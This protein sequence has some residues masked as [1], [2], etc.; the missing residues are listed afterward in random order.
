MATIDLTLESFQVP[1]LAEYTPPVGTKKS[2]GGLS[3][4]EVND[5][6]MMP[7]LKQRPVEIT[8][9]STT[10]ASGVQSV[11]P[12]QF[13]GMFVFTAS[14]RVQFTLDGA[15]FV[16]C[17]A[18]FLNTSA[19]IQDVSGINLTVPATPTYDA[20]TVHPNGRIT[21]VW[22]GTE[23]LREEKLGVG[24]QIG[25][26]YPYFGSGTPTDGVMG[27]GS[28]L[29]KA[30]YP[31][32]HKEFG[33]DYAL[34]DDDDPTKFRI[35]DLRECVLVG[36]GQST[37]AILDETGHSHDVYTLGEFKDDQIQNITGDSGITFNAGGT[38]SSAGSG[39]LRYSRYNTV[40]GAGGGN[41]DG[42]GVISFDASRV[43]RTGTTTHQK[44]LGVNFII[45]Y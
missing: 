20:H 35:P 32:L 42:F 37:R 4:R 14:S 39:A 28:L 29:T 30:D 1:A 17:M 11:N 5:N 9:N 2:E 40:G 24:K 36:A 8:E 44:S 23:W 27:D 45:K 21:L 10:K 16:G 38:A 25:E 7:W 15:S 41:T 34:E 31:D 19:Y 18:T 13:N 26:A 43:V 3:T 22:T 12:V 33:D 6:I